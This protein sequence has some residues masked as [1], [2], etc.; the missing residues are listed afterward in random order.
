MTRLLLVRHG[1]TD[2][3]RRRL[4]LSRSDIPLTETG[5]RQAA[6]LRNRLASERI[7]AVFTSDLSRCRTTAETLV[8][9]RS[10]DL[11]CIPLLRELDLGYLEGLHNDQVT[12]RFPEFFELIMDHSNRPV[13]GGKSLARV[14]ERAQEFLSLIGGCSKNSNVLVVSHSG[15]IRILLCRLLGLSF[16]DWWRFRIDV[17]SLTVAETYDTGGIL[18]LLNDTSHLHASE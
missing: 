5:S 16:Y 18:T 10:V 7:D 14:D 3:N 15:F 2:W 17:A 9:G 4:Y 8:E 6:A 1:E 11:E 12:E 13:P